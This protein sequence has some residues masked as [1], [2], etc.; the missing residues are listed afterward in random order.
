VRRLGLGIAG[1]VLALLGWQSAVRPVDFAVYHRA[2]TQILQGDY[3]LYPSGLYEGDPDVDEHGF[4][5][6]PAIALL[7]VPLAVVPLP[8][9]AAFFFLVK[10][11]AYSWVCATLAKR[12]DAAHQAF[13]LGAVAFLVAG[14]YVAEE[15]RN[16]NFHSITVF[17]MVLAFVRAEAGAVAVPS[18]AL[19]LAAVAKIA[20]IVLIGDLVARRR[21][22]VAAGTVICALAIAGLPAAIWGLAWNQRL[23]EGFFRYAGQKA[24][25]AGNYSLAG[26]VA[27]SA[28][29]GES[30]TWTWGIWLGA[31][32]ALGAPAI[33][34]ISHGRHRRFVPD[35][36]LAIVLTAM[37]VFSPHTQ[38][39]HF[40]SLCV[41]V[42][43]LL[44]LLRRSALPWPRAVAGALAL[45]ALV[46]TVLPAVLSGRSASLA[47]LS[48]SPY[49]YSTILLL[50]VEVATVVRMVRRPLD[51]LPSLNASS[52]P[53]NAPP[54]IATT[55]Y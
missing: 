24:G 37:P 43:I 13:F 16:G 31:A 27:G 26:V 39:I 21:F 18:G 25:D 30:P 9:A 3:E 5:Y 22:A 53:A 45:T 42:L 34:A 55:R 14:G 17:L 1:L 11:A 28:T 10:L 8:A 36:S 19:A 20:P 33:W 32:L 54:P 35:L 2:G 7:F 41:P 46:S 51:Q 23:L 44:A 6:A 29:F 48:W 47:Y 50:G 49:F 52:S 15:F 12:L 4:R 40:A 38:R